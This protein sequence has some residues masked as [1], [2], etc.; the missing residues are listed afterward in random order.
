[1]SSGVGTATTVTANPATIDADSSTVFTATVNAA[2]GASTPTGSVQFST[3][4]AVLGTA[5][6][7]GSGGAAK[8]SITVAGSQLALGNNSVKAV[9]SGDGGFTSSSGSTDV[10][11]SGGSR[12]SPVVA[13]V[14]P[15]PVYQQ[16]PDSDGYGWYFTIRISETAGIKST[17]TRFVLDGEDYSSYIAS[18]FGSTNLAPHGTLTA[19]LRDNVVNVPANRV[20]KFSGVDSNGAQWSQEISVPFYGRPSNALI[21]LSSSPTVVTKDAVEHAGCPA[22]YL[23]YQVL[24]VQERNGYAVTLNKF[25]AGGNDFSNAIAGWFGTVKLDASGSLQATICWQLHGPFPETLDYEVD[26]VDSQGNKVSATLS[27]EFRDNYLGN[28]SGMAARSE[29]RS[30]DVKRVIGCYEGRRRVPKR[31]PFGTPVTGAHT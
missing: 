19:A 31:Y 20:F 1:V 11:V 4:T 10:T 8:T 29:A 2:S 24:T 22:G 13:R 6:L 26:G 30:G 14:A 3:P 28:P 16:A 7:S 18:W 12:T 9:Y 23:F 5:R 17:V 27:V 21:S 15:N 25:L